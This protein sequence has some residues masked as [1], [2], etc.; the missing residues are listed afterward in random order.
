TEPRRLLGNRVASVTLENIGDLWEE[1]ATEI[2][3][4]LR[5]GRPPAREFAKT[6]AGLKARLEKSIELTMTSFFAT[7]LEKANEAPDLQLAMV[8][9]LHQLAVSV[10]NDRR[11]P[12]RA[13]SS[14][15]LGL[16]HR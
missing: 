13:S 12:K 5:S 15:A 1:L 14:H 8:R 6:V 7:D 2:G 3:P 10:G 4:L 11:D 16:T 9:D